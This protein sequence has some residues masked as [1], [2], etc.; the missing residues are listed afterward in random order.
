MSFTNTLPERPSADQV[1]SALMEAGEYI[2]GL[3]RM[4]PAD[5]G[6]GYNEDVR[7]AVTFIHNYDAVYTAMERGVIPVGSGPTAGTAQLNPG[8]QTLGQMVA[9]DAQYQALRA[10]HGAASARSA[11]MDIPGSIFNHNE[12]YRTL[13]SSGTG[14]NDSGLLLPKGQPLLPQ[15]RQRRL[16]VRDLISVQE[17][18]L[19]SV[20]YIR[21]FNPEVNVLGASSVAESL[22]KP[23]VQLLWEADDAPVRKIAA[24]VP[25]TTEIIEDVPTLS[26][27]IDTRLAYMLAVREEL[28][29]LNGSGASPQ[30]KG[31]LNFTGVQAQAFI[32]GDPM[33]TLGRAIGKVEAV[34]GEADGMAIE[35]VTFWAMVTTRYA[36]QF[37]GGFG[38]GVPYGQPPVNPW[39]VPVV[40]SRAVAANTAIVGSWAMGATLF[41][42]M[43]TTVR[44]GNQHSDYFTTN[45]VAVLAE[46][47]V[48]LAVVRPDFFVVAALV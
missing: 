17:T 41:D 40:R 19:A 24:W 35:P 20:P 25:V 7:S 47:R 43:Q 28:Q 6:E 26:G 30:I 29:I 5:R 33:A 14:S 13:V 3:Q 22:P 16:F 34:D 37:D 36:N 48:A 12:A 39:G 1:R 32:A 11:S 44:V 9:E 10:D 31:I 15:P 23:E 18:G 38:S 45:K 21:E 27:Y 2:H 46:E 4:A 8:Y 42:R